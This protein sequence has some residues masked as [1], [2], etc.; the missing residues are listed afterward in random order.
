MKQM[1]AIHFVGK[2]I[3]GIL[4]AILIGNAI[5]EYFHTTPFIMMALLLYVIIGSLYKLVKDTGD[6]H[7][8]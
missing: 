8:R 6:I 2:L 4:M 5:D 7:E 1:A 3:G